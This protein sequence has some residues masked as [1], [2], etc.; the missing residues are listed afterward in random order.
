MK[1]PLCRMLIINADDYGLNSPH[2][3]A[4]LRCFRDGL[5][6]SATLMPNMPAF[7]EACQISHENKLINHIGMHLVL[8]DGLPLTV[9]IKRFP[10]FCNEEGHLRISRRWPILHLTTSERYV[11]AE[12]IRAQIKLCRDN[13]I[14]LTHLDSHHHIH[15]E[16]AI[17]N[18]LIPIAR[19]ENI[20]YIR[21][22][23]NC[24]PSENLLKSIYKLLFNMKLQNANV[25]RTKYFGSLDDYF[26]LKK[27]GR[28]ETNASFEIM[29]HPIFDENKTLVD[30]RHKRN[31]AE[32]IQEVEGYKNAVSF[33]GAK[34]NAS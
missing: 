9:K 6:S 32:V 5:C 24:K 11:L 30:G 17:V 18:V 22:S 29:I 2:N 1:G 3:E 15:T 25:A 28:K 16:W 31:L 7:E 13:A 33:K 12:E 34:Y 19:E 26:Y 27:R 23:R 8:Q 20:P 14:P 4:I 10:R 21:L